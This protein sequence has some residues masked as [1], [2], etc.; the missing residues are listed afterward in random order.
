MNEADTQE[1]AYGLTAT[2]PANPSRA[3]T[4]QYTYEFTGWSP[5]VSTTIEGETTFT[6]QYS[7]TLNQYTYT[8]YD[9]DGTTVLK[10]A[11]IDYGT[12]IVGPE[13][14]PTKAAD[15]QY[16]YVF[17]KWTPTVPATITEDIT[18]TAQYTQ[19]AIEYTITFNTNGGDTITAKQI[20]F[21]TELTDD[22]AIPT[23]VKTG[24]T[25]IAWYSNEGLTTEFTAT[26]M[27]ANNVDLYAKWEI[28][29]YTIT[30]ENVDGATNNNPATYTVLTEGVTLQDPTK[31]GYTFEGWFTD[32]EFETAFTGIT[33]GSTGNITVYA[34]WEIIDYTIT[35]NLNGG[36]NHVSNPTT[37]TVLT[38]GVTLQDPTKAG[39]TFEGWFTDSEF[40][41]AFTGITEGST[42]NITVYAEWEIIDY[43]ITYNLDGGTNHGDNPET[44][45]I[46]TDDITL[47]NPSKAGYTFEGWFA[48]AEFNT[49]FG[50]IEQ[51]T[52]GNITVYAEW[53]IIDYTITYENV[54]G[55]TNNNPATY[56]VLTEGVTLQDPTKAGYTFEGW[57][58]DSEFETAFTGI[59]EGST[60]NI[61]VYADWK[62]IDYT[63]TYNLD[64]GTN[65]GDNPE[66]YTILTEDITLQD[67]TK[68]GYTFEGWFED[69]E[70]NTEFGGIEQGTTGNITV[71]AEWEAITY[72][73]KFNKN[74]DD[75]TGTMTDKTGVV[76]GETLTITN[77]FVRAGYT[78]KGWALTPTGDVL[79][80][81]QLKTLTT[82][83]G[84]TVTLYAIWEAEP[85]NNSYLYYIIGGGILLILLILGNLL[86]VRTK[87]KK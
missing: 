9:E 43:T 50:G 4:A 12:A 15:A 73:V 71:Y 18:F 7:E 51:G 11:T 29:D 16:T 47:Q 60:G 87:N 23:P 1:V 30:Y 65:H 48:D 34:E 61:T 39:Y 42:G 40:E 46:L 38:E 28:I 78:F 6:A 53:E 8:F 76:Y 86:S 36:T 26:T 58:T 67:P 74:N 10:T 3:A 79:T 66:T 52:T 31:A 70:F 13:T 20:A 25:F 85:V 22:N 2:A 33:E 35:Y 24:Y 49:E 54:D 63:I 44:Y 14:N 21:G 45:T 19:T 75:A 84:V 80:A 56:T 17:D 68:A 57:F 5:A 82:T 27:P 72:T 59:T 62:I 77:E 69:A 32:S 64:G 83:E 55:A 41:T 81:I 37:Y